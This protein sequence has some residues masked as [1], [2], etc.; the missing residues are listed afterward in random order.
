MGFDTGDRTSDRTSGRHHRFAH[1]AQWTPGFVRA[2]RR[3]LPNIPIVV[4][5]GDSRRDAGEFKKPGRDEPGGQSRSAKFQLAD[6]LKNLLARS[7]VECLTQRRKGAKV[8][9]PRNC[10]QK[11][12]TTDGH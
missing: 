7:E 8:A 10:N 4:A 1:A 3:M 2:L 9:G 5:S 12:I 11:G 6:A